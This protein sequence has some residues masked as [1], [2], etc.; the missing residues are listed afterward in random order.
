MAS[1]SS[2]DIPCHLSDYSRK[3]LRENVDNEEG[4][5][6][7]IGLRHDH[8]YIIPM[9]VKQ[10]KRLDDARATA[11]RVTVSIQLTQEQLK[12]AKRIERGM[13]KVEKSSTW[14]TKLDELSMKELAALY[15]EVCA[16]MKRKVE[17]ERRLRE[18]EETTKRGPLITPIDMPCDVSYNEDL[19]CSHC[20]KR[21]HNEETKLTECGKRHRVTTSCT[22]C[23]KEKSREVTMDKEIEDGRISFL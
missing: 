11:G 6:L 17:E 21:T 14:S 2:I 19:Y 3:K 1:D 9:N 15:D 4:Y 20:R 23:K 8:N 12:S 7:S 5:A 10:R 13:V 18:K 16:A 22:E